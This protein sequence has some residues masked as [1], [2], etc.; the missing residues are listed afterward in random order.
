MRNLNVVGSRQFWNLPGGPISVA[1]LG[2]YREEEMVYYTTY[3][4]GQPG[5]Q[6]GIGGSGRAP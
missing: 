2:E 4:E 5:G 3:S 6:F 1:L